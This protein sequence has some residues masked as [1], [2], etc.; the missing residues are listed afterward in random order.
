LTHK[1]QNGIAAGGQMKLFAHTCASLT[2]QS[3]SEHTQRPLQSE[4]PLGVGKGEERKPLGED[5]VPTSRF[6]TKEAAGFYT[7]MKRSFAA[8]KIV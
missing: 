8:V 3:K 5:F 6:G 1:T 7:Q 2:A 4:R